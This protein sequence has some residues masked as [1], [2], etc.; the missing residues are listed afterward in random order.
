MSRTLT[1][2]FL[3]LLFTSIICRSQYLRVT[4][5]FDDNRNNW[6]QGESK[7]TTEH[8]R[9]GKLFISAENGWI[10]TIKPYVAFEKDF[11]LQAS[12][13]Q[14]GGVDNYGIGLAWGCHFNNNDRNY[15]VI[16]S[17]GYYMAASGIEEAKTKS[18]GIGEWVVY[19]PIKPMGET[20]IL[21]VEQRSGNLSFYINGD[22][23]FTTRAFRWP[24]T[25]VGIIAFNKLSYEVDDFSFDQ[26]GGKINLPVNLTKGFVKENLG[27]NINTNIDDL[28]PQ[29]SADGRSLYF[30]RE[31]YEGNIGGVTDWEDF[32]I[33]RL[34]GN[35]WSKA[36]NLGTPI[37]SNSTD[38]ILA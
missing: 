11:T 12:I 13:R 30:G 16:T 22:K 34:E 35:Q 20:N 7:G 24:G 26:G 27:P 36:E 1:L 25:E 23:V 32:Y 18:P 31:Y 10:T 5:S 33:S 29:I 3:S 9:D 37:N 14:T 21:R 6:Y 2:T 28:S 15:F 8:I 19:K 17:N 38:N 4:D